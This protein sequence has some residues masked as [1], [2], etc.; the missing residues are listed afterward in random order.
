[1]IVAA[2]LAFSA[3]AEARVT[4]IE[5]LRREPFASSLPFGEAGA[6]EKVS[7][8]FPGRA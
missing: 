1:L 7:G 5:V 4:R 2:L 3:A 6:Y 8:R